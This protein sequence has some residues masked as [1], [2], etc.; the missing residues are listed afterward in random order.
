M[1]KTIL[2]S[3]MAAI[4]ITACALS[5]QDGDKKEDG[6]RRGPSP[7]MRINKQVKKL[8]KK[9]DLTDEQEQLLKQYYTEFDQLQQARMEQMR[10]QERR[11]RE[12]LDKK[13]NSILTDEQKAKYS[14]LKDKMKDGW[15]DRKGMRGPDRDGGRGPRGGGHGPGHGPGHMGGH[16]N[17]EAPAE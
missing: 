11:E 8:D 7:E 5:Q 15:K 14:E 16:G 4:A 3:L 1:K 13:I 12:D 2:F 6:S 10:Q 9:L 17:F